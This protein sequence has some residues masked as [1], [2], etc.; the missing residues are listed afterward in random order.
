T[1]GSGKTIG[2]NE[3]GG[4]LFQVV[5]GAAAVLSANFTRPADTTAYASGDLVANSTTAGLV[6][7]LTW[8]VARAAGLSS[9]IRRA[10]LKKSATSITNA[11][12]RLHLYNSDPS[13]ATGITNG[14]NGAFLTKIAGYIGAID[15]TVDKAFSDAAAG[16]GAP[17]SGSDITCI[18]ASGQAIYG[19]IEARAAYTP[20]NA[21]TFTVEL[22]AWQN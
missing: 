4:V 12:F 1:P 6:T 7:P 2:A 22:E 9:V 14:D 11:S 18:P 19:L 3:V 5:A 20:G 15:I 16:I 21:E 8:N 10:R 13:A 17:N